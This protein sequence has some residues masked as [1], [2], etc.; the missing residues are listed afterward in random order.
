VC[1]AA[2]LRRAL[3]TGRA[4]TWAP[5]LIAGYGVCL[6]VAGLCTAD[7]SL[8]FPPGTPAGPGPVSWHGM[9]HLAAGGIGFVCL[10][11][12]CFV[13]ARRFAVEHRARFAVASRV[14][15]V[16]FLLGFGAVATGHAGVVGNLAF[17]AAIV[18]VWGWLSAVAADRYATLSA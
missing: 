17:T 18:T 16:V 14:V 6:V 3:R 1:F 4:A 8:G 5:R 10:A 2:G 15:G 12:A 9:V 11:A 13:L 7:P